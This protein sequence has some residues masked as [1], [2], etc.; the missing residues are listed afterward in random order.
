[1]S[2]PGVAAL[3]ACVLALAPLVSAAP[4]MVIVAGLGG[5]PVYASAF[6]EQAQATANAVEHVA[7][8]VTLLVGEDAGRDRMRDALAAYRESPR[9]DP[10]VV[11]LIGHGSYDGEHY[12]FNVPGPD[13]TAD[14]LA[15]WL[16]PLPSEHQ[17]VVL[18]TSASGAAIDV[19]K[20]EG[21][22]VIAATKD[23]HEANA[24]VFGRF[25]AAALTEPRA[26][27]DKDG[28][29][30]ADEAFRFVEQAVARHYEDAQRIA[31]EHPRSEGDIVRF[32]LAAIAGEGLDATP[33]S[34][35]T[36]RD[37]LLTEIDALRK[38]KGRHAEEEY[39]ATLQELLLELSAVE[40]ELDER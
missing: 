40:S 10:V 34:A 22:A 1:M 29:I 27:I 9:E 26:D 28:R 16:A 4:H 13:P 18:A 33:G 32:E 37:E 6:V 21:R 30:D 25:W 23:G 20:D 35:A 19:L 14:E 12:R 17:L 36:R 2:G 3:A 31:T 38:A 7:A 8:G 15:D 39:F 24:V 11:V 5:E